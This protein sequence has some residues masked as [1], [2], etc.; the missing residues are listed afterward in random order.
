M[1]VSGQQH[2]MV[3]LDGSGRVVR[4]AKIWCDVESA[5]QAEAITQQLGHKVVPGFTATKMLWLAEN[6]PGNWERTQTVLLPSQYINY[7]LTGQMA[8]EVRFALL[9]VQSCFCRKSGKAS[10]QGATVPRA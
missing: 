7:F 4:N 10:L 1:A 5:P 2:G 9:S 3:A 8:M 6:E